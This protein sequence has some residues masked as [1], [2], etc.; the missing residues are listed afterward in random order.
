MPTIDQVLAN[1]GNVLK[2]LTRDVGDLKSQVNRLRTLESG[3]WYVPFIL[4]GATASGIAAT[5]GEFLATIPRPLVARSWKQSW[6]CASGDAT[7]NYWTIRLYQGGTL[8]AQFDTK[9]GPF[10][11]WNRTDTT[12][13]STVI[14]EANRYLYVDV[15]KTG[16]PGNL[17]LAAPAVYVF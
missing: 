17:S 7:T 10:A 14:S 15:V 3:G 2:G 8:I 6:Y 9:S 1:M 16:A 5:G 11:A 12:G 4:Y 13:L